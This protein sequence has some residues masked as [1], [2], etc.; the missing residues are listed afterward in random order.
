MPARRTIWIACEGQL[1]S[2]HNMEELANNIKHILL[3]E[4]MFLAGG[5]AEEAIALAEEKSMSMKKLE[6]A[7]QTLADS[8]DADLSYHIKDIARIAQE[9]ERHFLAVRNGVKNLILRLERADE[10]TRA[11]VYNQDGDNVSFERSIG[12]YLKKV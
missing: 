9:N 12:G 11:G 4:R 7:V 6:A 10:G 1:V 8:I 3:A 2:H 5:R